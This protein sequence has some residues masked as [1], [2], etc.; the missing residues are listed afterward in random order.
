MIIRKLNQDLGRDINISTLIVAVYALTAREYFP[1]LLLCEVMI[2]PQFSDSSVQNAITLI[3]ENVFLLYHS[4]FFAIDFS[5]N[6][7]IIRV[8]SRTFFTGGN[9]MSDIWKSVK[10]D[11]LPAISLA[12]FLLSAGAAIYTFVR[13]S[14]T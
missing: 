1:H 5:G 9:R 4:E 12:Q 3:S 14:V 8:D 6:F 13:R 11:Y 7:A 10:G 2:L